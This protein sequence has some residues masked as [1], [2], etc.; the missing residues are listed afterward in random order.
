[1]LSA[2]ANHGL[3]KREVAAERLEQVIAEDLNHLS[4]I[5]TLDWFRQEGKVMLE[6]VEERPVS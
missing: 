6:E 3:G 4:T 2:L 5:E 1:V